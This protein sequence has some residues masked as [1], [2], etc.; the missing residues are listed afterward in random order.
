MYDPLRSSGGSP[1]RCVSGVGV[2]AITSAGG[3]VGQ[4]GITLSTMRSLLP[5]QIQRCKLVPVC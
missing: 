4:G 2:G 1:A 3:G 5:I